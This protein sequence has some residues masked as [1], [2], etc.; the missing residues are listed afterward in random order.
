MVHGM[1]SLGLSNTTRVHCPI[2]RCKTDGFCEEHLSGQEFITLLFIVVLPI[3]VAVC[4][5][6]CARSRRLTND[7]DSPNSPDWAPLEHSIDPP[8]FLCGMGL[9]PLDCGISGLLVIVSIMAFA[10]TVTFFSFLSY[11]TPCETGVGRC[12]TISCVCGNV[13]FEGYV[14]MFCCLS[15]TSVILVQ[16][17]S[18]MVSPS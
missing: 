13:F 5:P 1:D 6:V 3:M 8:M 7:D 4:A 2:S 18:K 11:A 9:L 10:F 14:F 16:R 12:K 15:M 17:F